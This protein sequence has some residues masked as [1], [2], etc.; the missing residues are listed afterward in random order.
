MAPSRLEEEGLR[1]GLVKRCKA[2]C[3]G[4]ANSNY[5]RLSNSIITTKRQLYFP[6]THKAQIYI[7]F[8]T[9]SIIIKLPTLKIT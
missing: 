4:M 9:E 1:Q 8:I 7:F 6:R 3:L 5:I 2:S